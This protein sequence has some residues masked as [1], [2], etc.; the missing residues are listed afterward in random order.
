MQ[1]GDG[2]NKGS[3]AYDGQRTVKTI[4]STQ[5]PVSLNILEK[6]NLFNEKG[7]TLYMPFYCCYFI[8]LLSQFTIIYKSF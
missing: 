8:F 3:Y 5:F 2:D 7:A 4:C 1:V 6:I